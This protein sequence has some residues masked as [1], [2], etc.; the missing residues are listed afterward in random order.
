MKLVIQ[1]Q[2]LSKVLNIAKEILSNSNKSG[3]D[4]SVLAHHVLVSVFPEENKVVFLA[5]DKELNHDLTV[6]LDTQAGESCSVEPNGV[7]QISIY[8]ARLVHAI[9]G[10]PKEKLITIDSRDIK[11]TDETVSL[12]NVTFP[13]TDINIEASNGCGYPKFADHLVKFKNIA[14]LSISE[15]I[16]HDLIRSTVFCV[17]SGGSYHRVLNNLSLSL[18]K[19]KLEAIG[20]DVPRIGYCS[21]NFNGNA[22]DF[23]NCD[24]SAVNDSSQLVI[25]LSKKAADTLNRNLG[26]EEREIKLKLFI[27]DAGNVKML[28]L[29]K[30]NQSLVFNCMQSKLPN[31]GDLIPKSVNHDVIVKASELHEHVNRIKNFGSILAVE[32]DKTRLLLSTQDKSSHERINAEIAVVSTNKEHIELRCSVDHLLEIFSPLNESKRARDAVI[33]AD[34]GSKADINTDYLLSLN[35][36]DTRIPMFL[37]TE[38]DNNEINRLFILTI[39]TNI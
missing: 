17:N 35:Y 20:A 5:A 11:S 6:F 33:R 32:S 10:L 25:S 16:L 21:Y 14:I 30:D 19:D 24:N 22:F 38:V 31:I 34:G 18:T 26:N 1:Q 39:F 7:S 3:D 2:K 12:A 27:T 13:G 29:E 23:S 9:S 36:I 4:S 15:R 8:A 28:Q 37:V